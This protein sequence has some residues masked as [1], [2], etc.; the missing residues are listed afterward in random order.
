MPDETENSSRSHYKIPVRGPLSFLVAL[1]E[2]FTYTACDRLWKRGKQFWSYLQREDTQAKLQRAKVTLKS[3]LTP[4]QLEDPRNYWGRLKNTL[5]PAH[6]GLKKAHRDLSWNKISTVLLGVLMI[7]LWNLVSP[8]AALLWLTFA[9][10]FLFNW[11]NRVIA[12]ATLSGLIAIPFVLFWENQVLAEQLAILVYYLLGITVLLQVLNWNSQPDKFFLKG[13]FWLVRKFANSFPRLSTTLA[14][15]TFSARGLF[16]ITAILVIASGVAIVRSLHPPYEI[17]THQ[18]AEQEVAFT[19]MAPEGTQSITVNGQLLKEYQANSP[20]WLYSASVA[21]K[22]MQEGFNSYKLV[23]TSQTGR[24]SVLARVD[25]TY[26]P[27]FIPPI[28]QSPIRFD[29]IEKINETAYTL[30]G[31]VPR[32]T[33]SLTVNGIE[34]SNYQP[35]NTFWKHLLSAEKGNLKE[36]ENTV[37]ISAKDTEG[38]ILGTHQLILKLENKNLITVSQTDLTEIAQQ[39]APAV[40]EQVIAELRTDLKNQ[41]FAP[42]EIDELVTL[43]Q[44]NDEDGVNAFLATR[45]P[46][47]TPEPTPANHAA[48]PA[49]PTTASEKPAPS[50]QL[51]T[52]NSSLQTPNSS[53]PTPNSQLLTPD[54]PLPTDLNITITRPQYDRYIL[55]GK[56]LPGTVTV[57][58]NGT[59]LKKFKAGDASWQFMV[60]QQL[61]NLE[62]GENIYSVQLLDA[63]GKLIK[64]EKLTV[65]H[66]L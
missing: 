12:V 59:S 21:G 52:P 27:H 3:R 41:G 24:E 18:T 7:I 61:G 8:Q 32:E 13:A 49:E 34:A 14:L 38:N 48:A 39:E 54:S 51:Q 4:Y 63:Q 53:L 60:N 19:G 25:V 22:T 5:S 44:K 65:Y 31:F 2:D 11:D 20:A 62:E 57:R 56:S 36:G 29:G 50:S 28:A 9:A 66:W 45:V 26:D 35:F 33:A 16:V 37:L 40:E 15:L 42:Q 23:A 10:F 30:R 17:I 6:L 64:R 43:V 1:G 47:T 55:S 46:P 58:V